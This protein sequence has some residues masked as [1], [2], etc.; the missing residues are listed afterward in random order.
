MACLKGLLQLHR[1]MAYLCSMGHCCWCL[2]LTRGVPVP[3]V[4]T[5]A[6]WLMPA[7][8]IAA[9]TS[10]AW[11]GPCGAVKPLLRPSWFTAEP[12]SIACTNAG[13]TTDA[14]PSRIATRK[15]S[16][17]PYPSASAPNDLQR[18]SGASACTCV[19]AA[20]APSG[21]STALAPAAAAKAH[22][23]L[24]SAV[25]ARCAATRELLQAVLVGTHGPVSLQ[26]TAACAKE[27]AF[28]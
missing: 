22:S 16:P 14:R 12:A 21:S 6:R 2:P 3:C 28:S 17:R 20:V 8:C 23:L 24:R 25:A 15:P 26:A 10:A 5:Y 19:M 18:P 1:V 27:L 7:C 4:A 9:V 11:L 13:S